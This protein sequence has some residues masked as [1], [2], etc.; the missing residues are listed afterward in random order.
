MLELVKY[1]MLRDM[2]K[3]RA[4]KRLAR[5]KDP[6]ELASLIGKIATGQ[7][8]D[9]PIPE[10]TPDE[11]RRVMSALGKRGGPKGGAARAEALSSDRRREIAKAGAAARWKVKKQ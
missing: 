9:K 6:F 11:V 4:G 8:E 10:P 7:I 3:P 1:V 5:P 2:A